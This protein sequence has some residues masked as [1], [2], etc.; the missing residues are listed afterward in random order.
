MVLHLST[1]LTQY[2]LPPRTAVFSPHSSQELL[3]SDDL[4]NR[5]K[6]IQKAVFSIFEYLNIQNKAVYQV[7]NKGMINDLSFRVVY[8]GIGSGIQLIWFL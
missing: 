2:F 3:C 4:V 5:K 1:S 6:Y 8:V 7:Y